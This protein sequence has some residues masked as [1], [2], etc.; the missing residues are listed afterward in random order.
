MKIHEHFNYSRDLLTVVLSFHAT[1]V[2]RVPV[3]SFISDED[4][5]NGKCAIPRMKQMIIN[6]G[7]AEAAGNCACRADLVREVAK[8][9]IFNEECVV[10]S[11]QY[12]AG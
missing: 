5:R 11:D 7:E 6:R 10:C 9:R 12:V 2:D 8:C 1:I 3:E 4:V